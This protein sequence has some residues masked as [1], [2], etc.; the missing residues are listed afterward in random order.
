ML[1]DENLPVRP[2]LAAW[3]KVHGDGAPDVPVRTRCGGSGQC[4]ARFCRRL[5]M[6]RAPC[7]AIRREFDDVTAPVGRIAPTS[8]PSSPFDVVQESDNGDPAAAERLSAACRP[9]HHDLTSMPTP[10]PSAADTTVRSIAVIAT[11]FP[12]GEQVPTGP[13]QARAH[14]GDRSFEP[15][16]LPHRSPAPDDA[17]SPH[18]LGSRRP[19]APTAPGAVDVPGSRHGPPTT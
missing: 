16:P 2:V 14:D 12:A 6:R 17:P 11:G 5:R 4:T 8:S 18:C 10:A 19:Q 3:E 7:V 9:R 13:E 15:T 1:A